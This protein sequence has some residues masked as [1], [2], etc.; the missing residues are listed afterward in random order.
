MRL[1]FAVVLLGAFG[2]SSQAPVAAE[3]EVVYVDPRIVPPEVAEVGILFRTTRGGALRV[4]AN[5]LPD[6]ADPVVARLEGVTAGGLQTVRFPRAEFT[7]GPHLVTLVLA[8]GGGAPPVEAEASFVI[9]DSVLPGED[10]GVP[11]VDGGIPAC[12]DGCAGEAT[13]LV[14]GSDGHTYDNRCLMRCAGAEEL[15]EG[16][17][18]EP[19][20]CALACFGEGFLPMCGVDGVTYANQCHIDCE[21]VEVEHAGPCF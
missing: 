5:D 10:G 6:A 12:E 8:P 9:A 15:F 19:E 18:E 17:C 3:I 16:D 20:D 14:C 1:V 13:V 21:G 4:E 11:P 2:C 7:A